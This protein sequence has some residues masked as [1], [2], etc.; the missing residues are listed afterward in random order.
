MH[1]DVCGPISPVSLR[2]SKYFLTFTDDHSG[3]T[4]VYILKEKKKVLNKFKKFKDL[5]KR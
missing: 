3:K 2:G 4:W 1:I 5:V